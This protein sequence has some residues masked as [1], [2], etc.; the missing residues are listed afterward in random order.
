[1][2]LAD[3]LRRLKKNVVLN[4]ET[5]SFKFV[6]FSIIFL[7]ASV[8]RCFKR[9]KSKFS[10]INAKSSKLHSNPNSNVFKVFL[11]L[12]LSDKDKVLYREESYFL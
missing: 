3:S 1:M 10:K 2:L 12:S 8:G 4:E 7:W 5:S 9:L 11:N 6:N